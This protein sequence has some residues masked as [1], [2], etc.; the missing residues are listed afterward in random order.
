[1]AACF[2]DLG[3]LSSIDL[4]PSFMPAS[5]STLPFELQ[6]LVLESVTSP[7]DRAA[8]LAAV[9]LGQWEPH[10]R[11]AFKALFERW[12]CPLFS[13]ALRY[14]KGEKLAEA[15]VR[16]Y[17]RRH[18]GPSASDIQD[19]NLLAD[20]SLAL[21]V[22]TRPTSYDLRFASGTLVQRVHPGGII[23]D[24]EGRAGAEHQVRMRFADGSCWHYA[25]KGGVFTR[26]FT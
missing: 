24:F 2:L 7:L 20:E 4:E 17:L 5:F 15:T 10:E 3:E 19:L 25:G 22:V 18:P 8:V 9:L 13:L 26:I 16:E 21:H 6:R 23:Q 12:S 14:F 1:M 11:A